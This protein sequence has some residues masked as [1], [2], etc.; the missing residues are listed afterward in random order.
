[1]GQGEGR[2]PAE[3]IRRLVLSKEPVERQQNIA[4]DDLFGQQ[5]QPFATVG[6]GAGQT[7]GTPQLP[8][9]GGVL[10]G[11]TPI[12][13]S[14]ELAVLAGA[15]AEVVAGL[16]TWGQQ[17]IHPVDGIF[18]PGHGLRQLTRQ[19]LAA[20]RTRRPRDVSVRQLGVI[21]T[22]SGHVVPPERPREGEAEQQLSV[23][24]PVL[25]T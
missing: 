6:G 14:D 1:V 2:Q 19:L 20:E 12:R 4:V 16:E 13:L 23:P 24:R 15:L 5:R 7:E 8:V 10:L 9:I 18:D 3:V 22:G 17:A 11:K 25:E 21:R